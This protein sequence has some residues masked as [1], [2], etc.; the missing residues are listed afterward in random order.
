MGPSEI[1]EVSKRKV[2]ATTRLAL[3]SLRMEKTG[4]REA[5]REGDEDQGT[6]DKVE[7]VARCFLRVSSLPHRAPSLLVSIVCWYII[8][9]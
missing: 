4:E 8:L 9:N 2:T 7:V 3:S 5:E 1:G 6:D